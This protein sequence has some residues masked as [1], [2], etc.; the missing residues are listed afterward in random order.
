MRSLGA[1]NEGQQC[2]KV[3]Q[4]LE[5][6]FIFDSNFF[7][8]VSSSP[9]FAACRGSLRSP[10]PHNPA[11]SLRMHLGTALGLASLAAGPRFARTRSLEQGN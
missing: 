6:S 11:K 5:L 4:R 3:H 8:L 7:R 1:E 10:H 2:E 9:P